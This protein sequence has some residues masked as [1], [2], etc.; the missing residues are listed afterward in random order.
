MYIYTYIYIYM[1]TPFLFLL[2]MDSFTNVLY[3][4]VLYCTVLMNE[5]F[6]FQKKSLRR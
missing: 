6:L 4:T 3:Y 2:G 5:S 1:A